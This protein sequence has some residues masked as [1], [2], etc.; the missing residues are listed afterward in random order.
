MT[1]PSGVYRRL[2]PEQ[3][4]PGKRLGR[5][6]EHDPRSL[7]YQ[8]EL[9][10]LVRDVLHKAHGLP[11]DQGDLGSCTANALC[12]AQNCDPNYP[13][14]GVPAPHDEAGAVSL[15]SRETADEG[16][17]YPPDDPGGTGLAVCK[18]AKELGWLVRYAHTFDLDSALRALVM[19]PVIVGMNW[20]TSFD[21]PDGNGLVAITPDATVRGGHEVVAVGITTATKLVHFWNSWGTEY[22]LAGQF[23]MSW[24]TLEQ[25]LSEEGD[26]TVPGAAVAR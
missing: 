1:E 24:A 11:L 3:V 12:G 13:L 21:T 4:V 16:Q 17:P 23:S 10:P 8:A 7:D 25:L 20:Y 22:G 5:H 6:I 26:V 14:T 15:Y 18:A 19:R 9:A 2:I